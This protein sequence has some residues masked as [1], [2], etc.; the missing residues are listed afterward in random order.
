MRLPR[1][2][3]AAVAAAVGFFMFV[4]MAR[5]AFAVPSFARKYE[6]SCQTCHTIYPVLNPFGEAFRRNGYR[7]PSQNGSLDSDAVKAPQIPLGQDEY[8]KTFPDS[9]WPDRINTA[10]PLSVMFNGNVPV[11][12]PNSGAKDAAGNTFTWSGIEAEFHLFGAGAFS[13]TMTYMTQLTLADSGSFDIETAYL[14]WNDI[15]GPSHWVNLWVGRLWAPQLTSYGLHSDYLADTVMP[16]VSVASLFTSKGA[17]FTLGQGH[18]D[19][20]EINGIIGHRFDYSL[21]WVASSTATGLS[22]PNAEDA[23]AHIGVKSGGVALDGE[24]KY[25][26]NV[27]DP[28]KPWA[29]KSI[30]LDLFAYHGLTRADNGTGSS[31][32]AATPT[33]QDDRFN[34]VGAVVHAQLDSLVAMAGVQAESHDRPYA[35]SAATTLANGTV[36]PGVPDLTSGTAI[37]Q[38]DELDYVVYPWLIPGVRTEYTHA[39]VEGGDAAELLRVIPGVALLL[40]PNIKAILTGDL[41]LGKNPPATGSWGPAGGYIV[42]TGSSKFEAEQINATVAVAY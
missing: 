3:P 5:D 37:V 31:A 26:P 25:G 10:V 2:Q 39:T 1:W 35:G 7:F 28:R 36:L 11:N 22:L 29:E 17:G 16:G 40:R 18:T 21:G 9:I 8:K 24:G 38:Y 30:T 14:L 33:Q 23:Y 42:P 41:E 12:L 27:P 6:T 13:D 34:A 32:G 20:A 19:G 4:A 15:V